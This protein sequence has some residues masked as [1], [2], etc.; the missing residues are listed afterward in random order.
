VRRLKG[1][2]RPLVSQDDRAAVLRGLGCVDAVT[3]FEEDE[4]S[5]ALRRLRP[6]VWAKG[7]DYAVADL[8]ERA[9]LEEWGGQAVI[10][11][12]V[13][14]RSTTRMIEVARGA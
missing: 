11:P 3:V 4:P 2:D 9:V 5:A 14:G 13:A 1:A 7:G 8:P 10:V 6:D 12:Y